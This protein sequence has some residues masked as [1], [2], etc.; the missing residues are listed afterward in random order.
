MKIITGSF[1]GTLSSLKAHQLG[2]ILISEV[3]KRANVI[4]N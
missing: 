3:L 4:I 2:S 1:Y